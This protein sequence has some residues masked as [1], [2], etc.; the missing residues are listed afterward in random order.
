MRRC[1]P[2]RVA[3]LLLVLTP[4]LGLAS[5]CSSSGD[6]S[7]DSPSTSQSADDKTLA[8]EAVLTV[9]DLPSG[10]KVGAP[11]PSAIQNPTPAEKASA[12]A[13]RKKNFSCFGGDLSLFLTPSETHSAHSDFDGP[14]EEWVYSGVAIASTPDEVTKVLDALSG[15]NAENCWSDSETKSSADYS[16]PSAKLGPWK[17]TRLNIKKP[18]GERVEAFRVAVQSEVAGNTAT[19]YQDVFLAKKGKALVTIQTLDSIEP[20]PTDRSTKLLNKVLERLP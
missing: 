1:A 20:F 12:D 15:P 19:S 6:D 9:K 10:Y 18:K 4:V 13:E 5:S 11:P 17:T 2:C 3:T 14:N 16:D 8:D 7:A